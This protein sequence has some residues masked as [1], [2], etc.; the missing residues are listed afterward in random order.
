MTERISQMSKPKSPKNYEIL[1]LDQLKELNEAN[2]PYRSK[3]DKYKVDTII[4]SNNL[5][6]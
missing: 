2:D 1:D 4:K 3:K 6:I 5:Q